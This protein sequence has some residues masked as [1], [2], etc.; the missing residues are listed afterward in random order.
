MVQ[1]GCHDSPA[2]H[3][4]RG[5]VGPLHTC[6]R[7]HAAITEGSIAISAS[8]PHNQAETGAVVLASP[9]QQSG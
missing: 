1:H 5:F 8:L 6:D 3:A 9:M 7:D 2:D 4:P